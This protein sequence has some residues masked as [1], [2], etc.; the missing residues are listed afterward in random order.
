MNVAALVTLAFVISRGRCDF[1]AGIAA[2]RASFWAWS[3]SAWNAQGVT[4]G[5]AGLLSLLATGFYCPAAH[6]GMLGR[7]PQRKSH[8]DLLG[9]RVAVGFRGIEGTCVHS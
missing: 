2:R 7:D 9:T 3:S 5:R 6:G 8:A 4:R 1:V